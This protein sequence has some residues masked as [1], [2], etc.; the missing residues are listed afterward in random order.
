MMFVNQTQV[1]SMATTL[2]SA[3]PKTQAA[4]P[5]QALETA[6]RE[7]LTEEGAMQ[8]VLH[9]KSAQVVGGIGPQPVIDSLVVVEILLELETQVP[10]DLPESLVRAG[11]YDSVDEVVQHLIPQVEKRWIKYHKEKS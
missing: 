4:F 5:T 11:G 7:F 1:K 3:K 9:G 6:I 8:A 10:F 2:T